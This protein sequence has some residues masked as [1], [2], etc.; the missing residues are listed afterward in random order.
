[1]IPAEK[2]WKFK[3][4]ALNF[5]IYSPEN[6]IAA[7]FPYK[8]LKFCFLVITAKGKNKCNDQYKLRPKNQC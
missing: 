7:N 6:Y 3:T 4:H 1:M 8:R 2:N 5:K